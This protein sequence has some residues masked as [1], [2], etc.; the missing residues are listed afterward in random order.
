VAAHRQGD[1]R[2]RGRDRLAYELLT[3]AFC[4]CLELK[5]LRNAELHAHLA[6][7]LDANPDLGMAKSPYSTPEAASEA[8]WIALDRIRMTRRFFP[9]S[10]DHIS[11]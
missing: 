10:W 7:A 4:V 2:H 6:R 9:P 1:G 11:E 8:G 5:A 3:F